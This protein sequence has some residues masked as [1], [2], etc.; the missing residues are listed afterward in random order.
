MKN[1][2]VFLAAAVLA[3]CTGMLAAA[4][5]NALIVTAEAPKGAAVP[6]ISQHDVLLTV[7]NKPATVTSWRSLRT[8]P[9]GMELWVLIDDGTDSGIG[10][11]FGDIRNFVRH[12]PANTKV[13]I[14]YLRNGSVQAAQ[15]A[16]A[17]HEAAVKAIRL[18]VGMPG[19][20]ASPYIALAD[21]L[22]HLPASQQPR[23]VVLISSGVDPYY[24]PGPQN[25][26]LEN[27]VHEA[28]KSGVPVYTIYYSGAGHYG[29]SRWQIMWG[30]NDLS[31][32]SEETGGEFY[33]E[34]DHN[35]V[36]LKPYFD[37][38]DRRFGQQYLMSFDAPEAH[39]GFERLRLKTESS[40]VTLVGP[41]DA[42]VPKGQ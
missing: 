8:D 21:F 25:P 32:I 30:Q 31:Q 28:Q 5:V 4:P 41:L 23:E 33:W 9:A 37:D 11:Q 42:Y 20:S 36:S 22:H 14:G 27:A 19:I 26:Y 24:G 13:G 3:A 12:Q 29:H 7:D 17:D 40:G 35:P 16:T 2:Y 18:P 1:K 34:G 15:P 38:L 39:S 6:A 10:I